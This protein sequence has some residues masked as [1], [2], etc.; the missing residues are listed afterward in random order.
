MT[1]INI[2][3]IQ[4]FVLSSSHLY[5]IEFQIEMQFYWTN[6]INEETESA[7]DQVSEPRLLSR[8][9]GYGNPCF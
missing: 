6:F 9:I 5:F 3:S 8:A 2:S 4:S 7:M 1:F